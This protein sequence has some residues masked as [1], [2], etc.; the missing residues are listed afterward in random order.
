MTR[1][2]WHI[3]Q[4]GDSLVVSRRLPGRMDFAVQT[5]LPDGNRMRVAHQIRQDIWRALQDL[6][7]F[8][9]V[10]QVARGASGLTVEAG[11]Q[12]EGK[13]NR[14]QVQQVVAGVLENASNR[15]RW[16]AQATRGHKE[17]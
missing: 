9:P 15:A 16:V 13:F 7:G 8:A 6:R 14:E 11:G 5:D 1:S 12:V 10:V 2:T 3:T 17:T 4:N